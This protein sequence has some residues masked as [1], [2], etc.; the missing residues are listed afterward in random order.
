MAKIRTSKKL[1]W[2]AIRLK[3]LDCCGNQPGEVRLCPATKCVLWPFRFGKTERA[4]PQCRATG[5]EGDED[6]RD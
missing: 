1:L 5:Q 6:E 3:C 2:K 4:C